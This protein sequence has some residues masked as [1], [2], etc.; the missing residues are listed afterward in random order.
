M[1]LLGYDKLWLHCG[2]G[3]FTWINKQPE[4][5]NAGQAQ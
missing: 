2:Y 5:P 3:T 4:A 1:H